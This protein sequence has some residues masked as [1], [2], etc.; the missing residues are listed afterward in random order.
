[1]W[2]EER[3]AGGG[4]RTPTGVA[5]H[6][7]LSPMRLPI[8]PLQQESRIVWPL[9]FRPRRVHSS[10]LGNCIFASAENSPAAC[11]RQFIQQHLVA[12]TDRIG[13]K[14]IVAFTAT[15]IH[16]Q[17]TAHNIG[18][19]PARDSSRSFDRHQQN[20][21]VAAYLEIYIPLHGQTVAQ[22]LAGNRPAR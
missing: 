17:G 13:V 5:P 20:L 22:H 9:S 18:N 7:I 6:R 8:P 4:T 19:R 14:H 1:M 16:W 21:F 12:A 2:R 10:R 11:R 15:D 3:S